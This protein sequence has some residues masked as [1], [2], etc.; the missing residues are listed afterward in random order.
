MMSLLDDARQLLNI[1]PIEE[2]PGEIGMYCRCCGEKIGESPEFA[3]HE[4][5]CPWLAMPRIVAALEA[6]DA[7]LDWLNAVNIG[8]RE[9][10]RTAADVLMA[11]LRREATP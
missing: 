2:L 4:P 1:Q 10:R 6:A 11:A 7:A 8:D 9:A 3:G 5:D